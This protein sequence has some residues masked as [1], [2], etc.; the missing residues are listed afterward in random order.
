MRTAQGDCVEWMEVSPEMLAFRLEGRIFYR[1][2]IE[3]HFESPVNAR[4]CTVDGNGRHEVFQAEQKLLD[5]P[6]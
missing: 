6:G 1:M 3:N 4:E 2:A 5:S